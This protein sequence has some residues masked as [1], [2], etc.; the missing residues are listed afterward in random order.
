MSKT[1][2]GTDGLHFKPDSHPFQASG[3]TPKPKT[4]RM[5][6]LGANPG[7]DGNKISA[8]SAMKTKR[9]LNGPGDAR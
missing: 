6:G 2:G 4:A 1:I 9:P 8:N 3:K 7:G 5:V